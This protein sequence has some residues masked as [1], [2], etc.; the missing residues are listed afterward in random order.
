[1]SWNRCLQLP[2][3]ASAPRW[4]RLLCAALVWICA[5]AMTPP[6]AAQNPELQGFEVTRGD[7]GVYLAFALEV[8]LPRGVEDALH[9]GVPLYFVAQAELFRSRWYWRDKRISVAERTWRLAFQPLTRKYRVIFFGGLNQSYDSLADALV[10]V[11]R[12]SSWRIADG[13]ALEDGGGHYLE[14][15]YR[16][17]TS[18][19][20]RPLQIGLGGQADWNLRVEKLQRI[21]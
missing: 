13:Q 19:L 17:D 15:S 11:S 14:F 12:L 4:L 1:M 20:P 9:K 8:E 3:A 6:A 7:D 5:V 16:L 18:L 21:D 2:T 10:A